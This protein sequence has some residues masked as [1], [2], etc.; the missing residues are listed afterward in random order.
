MTPNTATPSTWP[1]PPVHPLIGPRALCEPDDSH[2][3]FEIQL[4]PEQVAWLDH[5]K[6]GFF[7]EKT[8]ARA[9][10]ALSFLVL[11]VGRQLEPE[12]NGDKEVGGGLTVL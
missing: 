5:G 4:N 3:A 12:Q 2:K 8:R 7:G 9:L 6:I 11:V 1:R 10:R